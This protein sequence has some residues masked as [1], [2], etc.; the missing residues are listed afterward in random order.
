MNDSTFSYPEFKEGQVLTHNDLNL[1]RDYL[2]TKSAFQGRAL[3]GFGVACGLEGSLSDSAL[4]VTSGFALAQ[5]G[6][7]LRLTAPAS[8]SLTSPTV[9]PATYGFIETAP[10]GFTPVLRPRDTVRAAGGTCDEDGC[11]THTEIH[12]EGVEIV[13]VAGRLLLPT[14]LQSSVFDLDPIDPKTNPTLTGFAG[15]RDALRSALTGLLDT[16]TLDLLTSAKLKLDGPPGLDLRKVGLVN[17]VLYTLCDYFLC[18]AS[19][20]VPCGGYGAPPTAVALGWLS[21]SSTAWK[22][23]QRYRHYF[24]LSLP[25]Y[26]GVHDYRGEQLCGRYLDHIRTLLQS[27]DPAP[28]PPQPGGGGGGGT[29]PTID[30]CTYTDIVLGRCHGWYPPIRVDLWPPRKYVDPTRWVKVTINPRD[31]PLLQK[32][33]PQVDDAFVVTKQA[34]VIDPADKGVAA[35]TNTL[36]WPADKSAANIAAAADAKGTK[37]TVNVVTLDEFK[38]VEGLQPSLTASASDTIYL[39][40]DGEG[41]VAATGVIPTSGTIAEIP[42][43]VAAAK[44]AENV[45]NG[46]SGRV[47]Q[48][49]AGFTTF[50]ASLSQQF[51]DFKAGFTLEGF[52]PDRFAQLENR[53]LQVEQEFTGLHG[54]VKEQ[55]GRVTALETQAGTLETRANNIDTRIDGV[56]RRFD[57]QATTVK[58]APSV[59]QTTALNASIYQALDAMRDAVKL[60]STRSAGPRVRATLSDVEDQFAVLQRE[61]VSTTPILEAHPEAVADVLDGMVAAVSAMGVTEEQPEMQKLTET[62]AALKSQL[63]IA[64]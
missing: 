19:D 11:T 41:R 62:V 34:G 48:M 39:G 32:L 26:R 3:I 16:A 28:A 5:G 50:K 30:F 47:G 25:L 2:Y 18:K 42:G 45:A 49:E 9:D 14:V 40:V 52:D 12:D 56:S 57:V 54:D 8:L 53:V 17:E 55:L 15:L 20:A 24:Q 33:R 35:I 64:G 31:D 43:T 59:A 63:G 36:G 61:S 22:W 37:T 13:L 23:D 6:R 4:A 10:G 7:E 60:G 51:A 44:N 38:D 58:T 1:L 27:F 21:G 29:G 46:I